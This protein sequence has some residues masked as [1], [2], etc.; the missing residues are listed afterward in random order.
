MIRKINSIINL[1]VF[2]GFDW[3]KDVRD[4]S[5]NIQD[6]KTINIIYGRN[7][8]GKTTLSRILRAMETGNLSDKF[9]NPSFI[10]TFADGTQLSQDSLKAFDNGISFDICHKTKSIVALGNFM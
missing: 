10:V 9:E 5:G 2:K 7:Y 6:F 8:S 1:A 3:D 4:D